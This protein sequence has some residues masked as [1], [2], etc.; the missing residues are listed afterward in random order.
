[1]T[2]LRSEKIRTVGRFLQKETYSSS[3][4]TASQRGMD[5]GGQRLLSFAMVRC[6]SQSIAVSCAHP[7]AAAQIMDITHWAGHRSGA[8]HQAVVAEVE[9]FNQPLPVFI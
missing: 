2:W 5:F 8:L 7:T 9:Q 6:G 3:P 1:M 4:M